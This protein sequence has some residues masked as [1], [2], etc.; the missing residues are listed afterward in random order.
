MASTLPIAANAFS[1]EDLSVMSARYCAADRETAITSCLPRS[2]A[3]TA[4]PMVPVAPMITI[5]MVVS[6]LQFPGMVSAHESFG[7]HGE[8]ADPSLALP[9][10]PILRRRAGLA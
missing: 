6:R 4:L 3:A 2:A 8:G 5:F 9:R 10:S 1:S 7:H